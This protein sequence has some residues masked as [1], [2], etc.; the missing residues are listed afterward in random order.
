MMHFT[1][2]SIPLQARALFFW[3]ERTDVIPIT[4]LP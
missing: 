2:V 1:P 3:K 4:P